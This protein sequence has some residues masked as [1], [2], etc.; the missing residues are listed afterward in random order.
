VLKS[1]TRSSRCYRIS[2]RLTLTASLDS[3][4]AQVLASSII[5]IS[6]MSM[7]FS[8]RTGDS[9]QRHCHAERLNDV[10]A[11]EDREV[12]EIGVVI[13][14]QSFFFVKTL[15][16]RI[17]LDD[18]PYPQASRRLPRIL[19]VRGDAAYFRSRTP[20]TAQSTGKF[21]RLA[22]GSSHHH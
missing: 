8:R 6:P 16:V 4:R 9:R 5:R 14:R 7:A 13:A 12:E 19:S 2:L 21:W 3:A 20:S 22:K 17:L 11:V 18:M 10:A 15:S 1:G